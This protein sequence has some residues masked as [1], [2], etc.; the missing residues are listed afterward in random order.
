MELTESDRSRCF[1]V[2][3][4]GLEDDSPTVRVHAAEALVSVHRPEPV[5]AAF[6]SEAETT[7]PVRRILVWRVLAAAEPQTEKRQEYL[8]RIRDALIDSNSTD[9]THAME[10]LA[11]L[12]APAISA[13]ERKCIH[14]VADGAGPASSFAL[15]RLVQSGESDAIDR[16]TRLLR[17]KDHVTRFRAIYVL[18]RLRLRSSAANAALATA[19]ATEPADSPERPILRA[20]VGGEAGRELLSD[21]KAPPGDRYFAAMFL[22]ESGT[23]SDYQRLVSLLRETNGD[24]RVSGAYAL[25]NNGPADG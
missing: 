4:R 20:A 24:L 7:E 25:L 21:A 14:S 12:E 23:A 19:L 13:T 9:Q 11:K 8:G 10:A 16:L 2:L 5:L 3:I 18:G 1:E 15:W 6:R 22:A 17:S